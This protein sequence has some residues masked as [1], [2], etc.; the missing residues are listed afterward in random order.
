M[1]V[2]TAI[3]AAITGAITGAGFAAAFA[4]AGTLTGLGI[5]TSLLAGGIA[6]ATAKALGPGVPSIQAQKDPGVK[7]QLEPSTDNR[8]PIYY[9]KSFLGGIAIDAMIK[10]QN[11][12]MVYAFAI[13]EQTDSGA[14]T[15]Q[16]VYRGDSKL[17]FGSGASAHIV[18]SITD[19]NGTS[20]ND[21]NGK[22]RC[23]VYA[24]NTSA[25]A[26]IFPT[27]GGAVTAVDADTMFTNWASDVNKVGN[28]T[29]IS[30]F[31]VDYDPENGLTGLGTISY[32]F[33]NSLNNPANVLLDYLKNDRYGAG[34]IDADL[35]LTSFDDMYATSNTYVSYTTSAGVGGTI[36]QWEINGGISAFQPVLTNIDQ[37]CQ[38]SATFFT[39]DAKQGKYKV[40]PNR[41]AT[42]GEK[43]NAFVFNDEN[44]VSGITLNDPE[45]YTT[46]NQVDVEY[47]NG[48][49][50]DQTDTVF[51]EV[52]SAPS[53]TFPTL[54][55]V[56]NEPDNKL[57]YRL[58]LTN[59]KARATNLANIDLRQA[60]LG[61]TIEFEADH[62]ALTVDIGDVV[63]VTSTKHGFN[64]ELYRAMR[65]TEMDNGDGT[66]TA[67]FVLMYYDD[68]VYDHSNVRV[69]GEMGVSNIPNWWSDLYN[70]NVIVGN[71][72][73]VDDIGSNVANIYDSGNA[74]IVG[75]INIPDIANIDYGGITGP[76]IK[77]PITIPDVP[78]IDTIDVGIKN[79]TA[80]D[81]GKT[82]ETNP[83]SV[84]LPPIA[85]LGFYNPGSI[86]DVT[87]PIKDLGS[88]QSGSTTGNPDQ[89]PSVED[90]VIT[91][92]GRSSSTG[93][94]TPSTSTAAIPI[95]PK[96]F[97]SQT[98]LNSFSAGVQVED[99]PANNT[100]VVDSDVV[101]ATL[102]ET[103][104]NA[105]I[106][107]PFNFD[108]TRAEPGDYSMVSSAQALGVITGGYELNFVQGGNITYANYAANGAVVDSVTTILNPDSGGTRFISGIQAAA[109][110]LISTFKQNISNVNAQ[111]SGSANS[112]LTYFPVEANV[113]TLANTNLDSDPGN[114]FPRG[115]SNLK[116][117]MLR[118]TK[119]DDF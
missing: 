4:A 44:I 108:L 72:T 19:P 113:I 110:P 38:N 43:A 13:G 20:S 24:G 33:N 117:D 62:T 34:L 23:R 32:E 78:G 3:A 93:A 1:A 49:A 74:A 30:I 14:V 6:I 71:V 8:L 87:V 22:M 16:D 73:I 115:F 76:S 7:V 29:V 64:N 11:N 48:D 107:G 119:G 81:D 61:R 26:Q 59:D 18:Q 106:S 60:R 50:K 45:L 15:I 37:I 27:P 40:V 58:Y 51:L 12:T 53:G 88:S 89:E 5:A 99:R 55:R 104:A 52:P 70:A 57:D 97:V 10:N 65:V 114:G 92:K 68:G 54:N 91:V 102:T 100:S 35:D 85:D 94:S 69:A 75:N 36:P 105:V 41:V 112:S 56:T 9:G 67:K 17:N 25:S 90:Y 46:Y 103:N 21:V 101:D 95:L 98:D 79:Q 84:V 66:L 86:I 63:K 77:F 111:T 28:N 118:I 116:F 42:S 39:F 82:V 2:F 31:E 96:A 109:P 83:V 80:E 47:A